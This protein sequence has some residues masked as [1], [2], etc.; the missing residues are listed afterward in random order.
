MN[1]RRTLGPALSATARTT[2]L[3]A[4]LPAVGSAEASLHTEVINDGVVAVGRRQYLVG[5]RAFEDRR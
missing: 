2:T 5:V 1:G 3:V 4:T